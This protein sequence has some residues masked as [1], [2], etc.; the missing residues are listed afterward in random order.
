MTIPL[1]EV[2][3]IRGKDVIADALLAQRK[4]AEY[5]VGQGGCVASSS[6]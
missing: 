1:L 5:V 6:G 4:L 2:V 3:D